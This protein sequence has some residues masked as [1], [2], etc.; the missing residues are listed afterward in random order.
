MVSEWVSGV[1]IIDKL[2]AEELPQLR[3]QAGVAETEVKW[4]KRVPEAL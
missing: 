2:N 3:L 1:Q 4:A